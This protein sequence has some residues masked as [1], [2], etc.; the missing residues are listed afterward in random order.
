MSSSL[1]N[2]VDNLSEVLHNDN[3][4]DIKSCLD[5][6]SV[7]GIAFKDGQLIC[8]CFERKKNYKKTLIKN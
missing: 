7:N 4:V 5:Y 1:S 8:R 3:C 2:I 6:L